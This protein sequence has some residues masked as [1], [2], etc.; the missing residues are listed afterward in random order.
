MSKTKKQKGFPFLIFFTVFFLLILLSGVITGVYFYFT[1]TRGISEIENTTKKIAPALAQAFT[2]VAELSYKVK[3]YTRLKALFHQKIKESGIDE[4]FFVLADGRIVAHSNKEVEN[5]LEGNIIN[6]EFSYNIDQ[7]LLP[8]KTNSR[9]IQIQDYNIL[10]QK[11]PFR[12]E[13]I[14]LLKEYI[15]PKINIV[16]WLFTKG[17]YGKT[18][19]REIPL[20]TINFIISK[21]NIYDFINKTIRDCKTLLILLG[22]FSLVLS[23]LFSLMV[24][25]RTRRIQNVPESQKNASQ[26][27]G[28]GKKSEVESPI[29]E[30]KV[31]IIALNADEESSSFK[32]IVDMKADRSTPAIHQESNEQEEINEKPLPVNMDQPILDAIPIKKRGNL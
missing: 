5:R 28:K 8:L 10:K 1:V 13:E 2:D 15:Y 22:S 9:E 14:K 31:E 6:D 27:A 24:F 7:I 29:P 4:A 18:K 32:P 30:E 25:I 17:V 19:K 26:T 3:N 21:Q 16:G 20:G 23:L 11:I 12:K